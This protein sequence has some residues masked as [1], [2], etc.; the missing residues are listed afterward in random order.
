MKKPR[1]SEQKAA[2]PWVYRVIFM[3]AESAYKYGCN[4]TVRVALWR[5]KYQM[6]PGITI[7]SE[8][9][10]YLAATSNESGVAAQKAS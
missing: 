9:K 3:A 6:K 4:R 5:R 7:A 8:R 10:T 1:K 2:T